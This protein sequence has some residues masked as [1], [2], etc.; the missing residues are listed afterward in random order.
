MGDVTDIQIDCESPAR[1][2]VSKWQPLVCDVILG[3]LPSQYNHG[4]NLHDIIEIS[5]STL[6]KNVCI[7]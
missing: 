4:A 5:G 1:L 2:R 7:V 6:Q 3:A